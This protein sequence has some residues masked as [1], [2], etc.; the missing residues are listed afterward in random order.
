MKFPMSETHTYNL[1]L[2]IHRFD[3]DT[4]RRWVQDYQVEAGR[5][6]RFVDLFRK[7]NDEQDP[8]SVEHAR[9]KSTAN[10]CW[11]ANFWWKTLWMT[12][13]PPPFR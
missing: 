13:T 12:S 1:T 7:I 6:L 8:A 3:P 5:I 2:K 11:P 9:L 4:G 10:P